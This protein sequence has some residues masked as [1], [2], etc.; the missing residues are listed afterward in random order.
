MNIKIVA[1]YFILMSNLI[2]ASELT[3]QHQFFVQSAP[4][5]TMAL[6]QN[7]TDVAVPAVEN[8]M[9]E[10]TGA[11]KSRGKAFFMSLLVPGW[12][13]HYAGASTKRNIFVGLEIGMWASYGG[14][15]AFSSWREQDYK[16]YAATHA[17]VNLD[18]KN[19]TYFIDVGNF[20][21]IY[22][23]NDYRLQQ[24]NFNKYYE[25]IDFYYWK[26][27]D[28]ASRE[29]F[30]QLRIS[31]DT[32]NNR[33]LFMLGAIVANHV[34][35]AIDAVWSVHKYEKS[36]LSQVDWGVQFGDGAGRPAVNVTLC[37]HF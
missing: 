1:I 36:R 17:G 15:T 6:M 34:I 24:R 31:A 32:A 23:H 12:G 25:D 28:Q 35:S 37:R 2:A 4:Y 10:K 13:Q 33:A 21:D 16:S 18:G 30:D 22:E 7:A 20:A 3:P 8:S 9:I 5:T 26:W 19:N 27:E 29:K 11:P 14:F